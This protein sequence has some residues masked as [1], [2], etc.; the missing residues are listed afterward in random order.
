MRI[1]IQNRRGVARSADRTRQIK[2]L[3]DQPALGTAKHVRTVG[4]PAE[5]LNRGRNRLR[6]SGTL[7]PGSRPPVIA[8][9]CTA[10]FGLSAP[11]VTA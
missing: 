3:Q 11:E 10:R 9:P 8:T 4:N 5:Q 1:S 7:M 6:R 2:R